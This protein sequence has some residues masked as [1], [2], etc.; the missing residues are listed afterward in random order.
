M[1]AHKY[2]TGYIKCGIDN[3]IYVYIYNYSILTES[4]VRRYIIM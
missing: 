3:L 2:F 4:L 1:V